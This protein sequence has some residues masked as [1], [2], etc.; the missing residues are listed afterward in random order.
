[1]KLM[2]LTLFLN[3]TLASTFLDESSLWTNKSFFLVQ[4]DRLGLG[5]KCLVV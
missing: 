1:M 4:I 3:P 5:K 2:Q